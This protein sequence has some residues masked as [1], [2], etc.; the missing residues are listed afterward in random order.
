MT[1]PNSPRRIAIIGGGITGLSA[2]L[3]LS[4]IAR[5]RQLAIDVTLLDN[6]DRLGGVLKTERIGEYLV[7]HAADAIARRFQVRDPRRVP[8]AIGRRMVIAAEVN[9]GTA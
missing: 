1:T 5:E 7:E 4:D 9:R 8:S 2:A 3:R 6:S